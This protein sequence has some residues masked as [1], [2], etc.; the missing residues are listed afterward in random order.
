[1]NNAICRGDS[2][3]MA[4]ALYK[5][6]QVMSIFSREDIETIMDAIIS[7][8]D[9]FEDRHLIVQGIIRLNDYCGGTNDIVQYAKPYLLKML[10][11]D[12]STLRYLAVKAMRSIVVNGSVQ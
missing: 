3:V 10:Q 8:H 1:M 12:D 9:N 2:K 4:W 6:A 5:F 11:S 7:S